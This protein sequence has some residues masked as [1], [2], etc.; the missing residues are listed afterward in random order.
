[1]GKRNVV[2]MKEEKL[3]SEVVSVKGK[4][5][6]LLFTKRT[7]DEGSIVWTQIKPYNVD[8]IISS[9]ISDT[10]SEAYRKATIWLKT[11]KVD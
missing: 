10:K 3:K 9:Y 5:Y 2:R 8:Y 1:M 4:S 6:R 11:I 7:D